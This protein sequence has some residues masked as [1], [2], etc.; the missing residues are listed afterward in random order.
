MLIMT[1]HFNYNSRA[2]L[3][4]RQNDRP[5]CADRPLMF[6]E[7]RDPYGRFDFGVDPGIKPVCCSGLRCPLPVIRPVLLWALDVE[8]AYKPFP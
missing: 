7:A 1:K 6:A 5:G 8:R 2:T 4:R 3:A